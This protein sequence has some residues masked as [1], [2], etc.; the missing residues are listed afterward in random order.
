LMSNI[1]AYKYQFIQRTADS[2]ELRIHKTT[3]YTQQQEEFIIRSIRSNLG[4]NF[5][6]NIIYGN[7]FEDSDNKHKFILNLCRRKN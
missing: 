7:E 2:L 3:S 5:D 6:F 1:A 4:E